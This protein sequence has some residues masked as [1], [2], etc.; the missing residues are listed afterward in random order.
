MDKIVFIE[1]QKD[2][3]PYYAIFDLYFMCSREDPFPLTMIEAANFGL[4]IIGFKNTGGVEE[5][6]DDSCGFLIEYANIFQCAQSIMTINRNKELIAK[7]KE[8]IKSKAQTFNSYSL[9]N[10]LFEIFEKL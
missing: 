6:V 1:Q 9:K 7:C 8:N 2:I 3:Y 10:K 5:F 4:P